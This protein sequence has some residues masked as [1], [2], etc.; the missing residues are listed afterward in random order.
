MRFSQAALLLQV[1]TCHCYATQASTQQPR[2]GGGGRQ[3]PA[4]VTAA[5]QRL[6]LAEAE[7]EARSAVLRLLLFFKFDQT[8]EIPEHVA[9]L[10]APSIGAHV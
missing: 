5:C 10:R 6:S 7:P 8:N 3:A 2:P 1:S 9:M 4:A